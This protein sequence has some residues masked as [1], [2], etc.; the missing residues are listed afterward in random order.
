MVGVAAIGFEGGDHGARRDEASD[1]VHVAV[2]VVAGDAA[3]QPDDLFHAEIVGEDLFEMFA[4]HARIALLHVTQQT[5]FGGDERAAAVDVD[6]AA[7]QHN[8][9]KLAVDAYFGCQAGIRNCLAISARRSR[10]ASNR[11]TSPRH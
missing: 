3:L 6:A 1:V 7:F 8:A 11:C 4:G 2:R 10:Q 9:L 5:L